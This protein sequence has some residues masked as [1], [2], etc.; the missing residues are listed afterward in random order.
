MSGAQ[1]NV[2][3]IDQ[4]ARAAGEADHHLVG[5]AHP[6]P[7]R[8]A[9]GAPGLAIVVP[10]PVVTA[11]PVTL[12]VPQ[13]PLIWRCVPAVVAADKRAKPAAWPAGQVSVLDDT[14]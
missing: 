13:T 12:M 3:L 10:T 11:V 2:W 9:G 4:Q 6:R 8:G 7:G 5:R 1:L 14:C